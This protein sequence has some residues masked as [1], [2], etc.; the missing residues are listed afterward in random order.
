MKEAYYHI[1]LDDNEQSAVISSLNDSRNER[2]A[3]GKS[4]DLY[5]DL[6]LKVAK[7][8]YKRGRRFERDRNDE[9]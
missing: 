8:P 4:T 3:E 5:D 6:I 1:A 7:A 2:I 9:R